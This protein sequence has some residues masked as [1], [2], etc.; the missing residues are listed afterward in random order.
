MSKTFTASDLFWPKLGS[1]CPHQA[2]IRD[3]QR[4]IKAQYGTIPKGTVYS[5][6]VSHPPA[7]EPEDPGIGFD[8]GRIASRMYVMARVP[9]QTI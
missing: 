2:L 9:E 1:L 6:R 7:W 5:Q 3:V 4:Q 8:N